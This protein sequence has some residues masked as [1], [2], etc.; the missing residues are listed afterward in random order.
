MTLREAGLDRVTRLLVSG[1]G[2]LLFTGDLEAAHLCFRRLVLVS[3]GDESDRVVGMPYAFVSC[4]VLPTL[5][6]HS[7]QYLKFA[8]SGDS[9]FW[10]TMLA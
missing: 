9:H 2:L 10:Q 8:G 5:Q 7:L 6:P 4:A 1:E 3:F